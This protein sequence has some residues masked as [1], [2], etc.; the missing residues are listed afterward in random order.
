MSKNLD[1]LQV[2][3]GSGESAGVERW[4]EW[5]VFGRVDAIES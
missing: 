3:P 5:E 4:H 2:R 1:T